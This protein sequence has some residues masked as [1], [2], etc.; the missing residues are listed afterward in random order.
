MK[1]RTATIAGVVV[2]ICILIAGVVILT[3]GVKSDNAKLIVVQGMISSIL[4][5][6]PVIIAAG[7]AEVAAEKAAEMHHDLQN[8]LIPQKVNEALD[9]RDDPAAR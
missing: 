1:A 6:I 8:G 9:G 4:G 5:L 2:I 3:M 7:K